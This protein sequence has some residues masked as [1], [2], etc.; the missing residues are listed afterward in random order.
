MP[1][2][3]HLSLT[4]LLLSLALSTSARSQILWRY[5]YAS[6][7]SEAVRKKRPIF[8]DFITTN[9]P[10]C[11]KM[12]L[13]TFSDGNVS[14]TLN[15]RF[16]PLKINATFNPA[17]ANA[18]GIEA[19]PTFVL[20]TAKG[21]ILEIHKGFLQPGPM[22]VM[23]TKVL[24]Q[25]QPKEKP[26]PKK[27]PDDKKPTVKKPDITK[28]KVDEPPPIKTTPPKKGDPMEPE[29]VKPKE[30]K[31]DEKKPAIPPPVV[32]KPTEPKK[33]VQPPWMQRDY[34][35]ADAA[36]LSDEFPKAVALLEKIL[37]KH[38]DFPI[39]KK[40]KDLL[41]SI[42][43]NAEQKLSRAKELSQQSRELEARRELR[44]LEKL[45]LGL[46][47]ANQAKKLR[48]RVEAFLARTSRERLRSAH[49]LME[50]ADN[51]YQQGMYLICL[52]RCDHLIE[53]YADL[54]V[55]KRAKGLL[56]KIKKDPKKMQK[57]CD[58]LPSRYGIIY[59]TMAD[60]KMKKGDPQQAIYYLRRII[61]A[62]PG[63]PQAELAEIRLKQIEGAP[64]KIEE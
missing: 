20:A 40:A 37:K 11:D 24:R 42:N 36:I 56:K 41:A 59:L 60:M 26:K 53:N 54:D 9:C 31:P 64:P 25:L 28:P 32:K 5:D 29:V 23:L 3:I 57:I 17:L 12:E 27:K 61:Q 21:K 35:K 48:V 6:A 34:D 14:R 43:R 1:R 44:E 38:Q 10:W 49:D 52:D 55:A 8:I 22:M 15:E 46:P 16:I 63:T 7:R 18:L 13:L 4:A 19:Y 51:D 47:I 2:S 33:P 50:Q 30:K 62:Y 39:Q 58:S 45:Y